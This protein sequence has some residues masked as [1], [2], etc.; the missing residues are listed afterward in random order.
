MLEGKRVALLVNHTAL[1]G[2]RHLLD[3]L[4]E[5]GVQVVRIFSPEHG[6]R[7]QADAGETVADGTDAATGLPV[8]SLYGDKK[9]PDPAELSDVDVVIY[10]IQDVGVRFYTYISTL[11][12]M[13]EACAD[14]GKGLI[15]FD[16]PNPNGH[17]VDGPVL[18]DS[19]R[20]FVG[21]HPI[22]VVHGL[23]VG[24]LAR[25]VNGE[26][27]LEGGQRC[28]L[29]VIPVAHYKRTQPYSLPVRPSPNLPNDRAVNLYP[30]V[31][32]FEGT[33]L[34]LGRGT[35]FPFQVVGYPDPSMG[36]FQFTP[37]SIPGMAKN[38]PHQDLTCYGI[39]L[40]GGTRLERLDLSVLLTM[41]ARWELEGPFFNSYFNKL[42]G[43][44]ALK[45]Q[46]EDGWTE[47]QIRETWQQ[48]LRAYREK[49]KPYLLYPDLEDGR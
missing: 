18:Q 2:D 14:L 5:N 16:R 22:P 20:S 43:H 11:H 32:F 25:M 19:L 37:V 35:Q 30:A 31:C 36:S 41:Y 33:V 47:Q 29:E 27:W 26:G 6:F 39:D 4:L 40:R 38:P 28:N 46:I 21:M 3:L 17:Y 15:V 42:A 1:V 8:I 44:G 49:R 48:D 34:S 24:E 45:G 12:Y 10:D 9:K 23:T 7:G 13:M